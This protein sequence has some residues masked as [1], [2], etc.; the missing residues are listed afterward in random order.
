MRDGG[1][2]NISE[3]IV[4]KFAFGIRIRS[5]MDQ[6]SASFCLCSFGSR[7]SKYL[8]WVNQ[9][10]GTGTEQPFSAPREGRMRSGKLA[11]THIS[12]V[13]LQLRYVSSPSW[14][15]VLKEICALE[16]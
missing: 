1:L 16:R 3:E 14:I 5:C 11:H 6:P 2:A 7:I 4:F 13:N 9:Q 15:S 12:N 8:I 10:F